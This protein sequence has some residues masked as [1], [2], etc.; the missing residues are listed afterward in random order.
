MLK[1]IINV[2]I[3]QVTAYSEMAKQRK[4]MPDKRSPE[5]LKTN[6]LDRKRSDGAKIYLHV[7]TIFTHTPGEQ[8]ETVQKWIRPRPVGQWQGAA[9]V[10]CPSPIAFS[11]RLFRSSKKSEIWYAKYQ[12]WWG[13]LEFVA[14]RRS[15]TE[16]SSGKT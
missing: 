13:S 1:I 16:D 11:K 5:W 2:T 3:A 12:K 14:T 15:K 8:E 7:V 9:Y 6:S 4:E 10:S